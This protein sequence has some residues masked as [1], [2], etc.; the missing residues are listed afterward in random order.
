MC[1]S[2]G[3]RFS[4]YVRAYLLKHK[5]LGEDG[6]PRLGKLNGQGLAVLADEF[7]QEERR[8]DKRERAKRLS[9]VERSKLYDSLAKGTGCN[10]EAMTEP[11]QKR[12]GVAISA[13]IR[14]TPDV[15]PEEIEAACQTYHREMSGA[16]I[17]PHAISNNW[18]KLFDRGARVNGVSKIDWRKEPE[19]AWRSIIKARWP[20]GDSR[21]ADRRDW[22][23]ESWE[24]VPANIKQVIWAEGPE[25][26]KKI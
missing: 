16:T 15:T 21:Y 17:T 14:A 7:E 25:I 5:L 22:E 2:Y 8:K 18:S 3:E 10:L 19:F 12:C 6:S 13:I 26:L 4:E 20:K 11:E 24:W 1:A 23:D 9:K